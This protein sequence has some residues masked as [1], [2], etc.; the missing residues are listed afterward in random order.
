M[1]EIISYF[2]GAPLKKALETYGIFAKKSH[3]LMSHKLDLYRAGNIA[4]DLSCDAN[5]R[6]EKFEKIYNNLKGYWGVFRNAINYWSHQEVFDCLTKNC[7]ACSRHKNLSLGNLSSQTH[8]KII[9]CLKE[10]RGI[11]TLH[12]NE[13]STMAVSKF[14]HFFNPRLFPIYDRSIIGNKVLKVFAD[15]WKKFMRNVDIDSN[16]DID[17]GLRKY[18]QYVLWA[19]SILCNRQ[20]YIMAE[21]VNF[22]SEQVKDKVVSTESNYLRDYYATAFEFVVIGASLIKG[23]NSR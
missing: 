14:L 6:R 11:K 8:V 21:F 13:T 5:K 2:E 19:N 4:F 12:S 7:E 22:F 16:I 15:D 23:G 9:K 20:N 1:R 18:F 17:P 10:I 3:W